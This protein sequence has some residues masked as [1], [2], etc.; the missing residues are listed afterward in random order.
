MQMQVLI[1]L[2]LRSTNLE[3]LVNVQFRTSVKKKK[4]IQYIHTYNTIH[5]YI[6]FPKVSKITSKSKKIH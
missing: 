5:T 2:T 3:K 4:I 1:R 6:Q